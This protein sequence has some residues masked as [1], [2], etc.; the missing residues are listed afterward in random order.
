M[1]LHCADCVQSSRQGFGPMLGLTVDRILNPPNGFSGSVDLHLHNADNATADRRSTI[2]ASE[3]IRNMTDRNRMV[4]IITS[5]FDSPRTD[6][7]QPS[8]ITLRI[9]ASVR[10]K[11]FDSIH[12]A[13]PAIR[14]KSSFSAAACRRCAFADSQ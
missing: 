14:N 12:T 8:S 9:R 2:T 1:R 13:T 6:G 7:I 10:G 3:R 5:G 11:T 4:M